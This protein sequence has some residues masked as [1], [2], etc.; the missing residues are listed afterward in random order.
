MQS[1]QKLE[2]EIKKVKKNLTGKAGESKP[3][4]LSAGVRPLRKKLKRL[5]RRRR[6]LK[7]LADRAAVA[8]SGKAHSESKPAAPEEAAG[9]KPDKAPAESKPAAPEEAAGEG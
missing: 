6:V 3:K 5:Q 1:V 4:D 7:S 8:K 9:M 2:G